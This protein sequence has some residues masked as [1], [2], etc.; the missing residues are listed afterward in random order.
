VTV[1]ERITVTVTE[2]AFIPWNY[3]DSN[4]KSLHPLGRTWA[5]PRSF[6]ALSSFSLGQEVRLA[7]LARLVIPGLPY[8]VTQRGNRR[9]TVTVHSIRSCGS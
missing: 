4:R 5:L 8:H 7:R 3:G 1:T 2:K 6:P 9:I